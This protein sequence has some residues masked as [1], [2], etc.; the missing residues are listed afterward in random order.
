MTVHA[1]PVAELPDPA[2][3][4]LT[5]VEAEALPAEL[6]ALVDQV[7]ALADAVA[8][9]EADPAELA[10]AGAAVA[11]LTERLGATRRMTGAMLRQRHPDG[12]IEYNTLTNL[13]SGPVNPTAPP[14]ELTEADGGLRGEVTLNGTY[15][16]PPGLVHG[17]WIAAMLDQALGAAAGV[18]GM[19]GLTANLTVDY[20]KPTP[21]N[22]PLTV[23]SRVTG[24]ER[25]KVFVSAEIRHNG[26]ITAEGT[27]IM[28]QIA[29]PG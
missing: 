25:R 9:T 22:A 16:G 18:A 5:V 4:G 28:V 6:I 3:Y 15:Q 29:L 21:L 14:L 27:A 1:E 20:R 2:D 10:E 12:R 23:T 26:E 11:A 19:P 7:R 17:G 8:H 13:V 24:T